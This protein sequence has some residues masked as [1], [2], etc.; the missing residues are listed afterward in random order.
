MQKLL[1]EFNEETFNAITVD[2]DTSTNDTVLFFATREASN[3]KIRDINDPN[4]VEFKTALKDVMLYLAKQVVIDGEGATKLIEIEVQNA[5][6][7]EA[8]KIIALSIANSPLVKT[9]IAGCD[10]NWGR[11]IMAIG[12]SGQEVIQEKIGIKIGNF[13]IVQNGEIVANYD[14]KPVHQY[15]QNKEVKISVDINLAKS[16]NRATVWTC[17]FTEG[18]IK[19]NKDYRS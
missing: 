5:A 7:K 4:L 19:I 16:Q 12:K 1:S 17:D 10:P 15:L 3:E 18:Y 14:E 13:Q 8:A 6:S 2:S 11:I 9:A